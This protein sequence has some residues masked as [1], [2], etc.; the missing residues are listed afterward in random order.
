MSIVAWD[1][2]VLAADM[3]GTLHSRAMKLTKLHKLS[4]GTL[5]TSVGD[6]EEGE[7]LIQWYGE[8]AK[9]EDWPTFQRDDNFTT[10][11]VVENKV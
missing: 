11:I 5:V 10:L 6:Q 3:Q 1:G 7:M 8:G 2:T 9:K 4:D